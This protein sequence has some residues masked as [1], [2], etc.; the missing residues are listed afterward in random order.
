M[1]TGLKKTHSLGCMPKYMFY[2][3]DYQESFDTEH[4]S[5]VPTG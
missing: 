2:N 1:E 4:L 3:H 5:Y